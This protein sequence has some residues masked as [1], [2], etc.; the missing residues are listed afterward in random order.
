MKRLWC[1][2]VDEH[3]EHE[4]CPGWPAQYAAPSDEQV[5]AR[6]RTEDDDEALDYLSRLRWFEDA[7]HACFVAN[8]VSRI[9]ETAAI[10]NAVGLVSNWIDGS[11]GPDLDQEAHVRR[12]VDKI[13]EEFGEV[14]EAV[15]GW[16]GENPRKGVTHTKA[17]VE[18]ELLDV[19]NAALGAYY[20]LTDGDS[21]TRALSAH[22]VAVATRAGLLP[23]PESD[24]SPPMPL[25]ITIPPMPKIDQA[26]IAEAIDRATRPLVEQM[27]RGLRGPNTRGLG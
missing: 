12:R 25:T 9:E 8:H 7:A 6:L 18:Y 15:G 10:D 24:T 11:Y 2:S 19:A 14:T 17:D 27:R 20:H 1:K 4:E 23:E 5:L 3:A 26:K 13:A 21:P 16:W 22:A